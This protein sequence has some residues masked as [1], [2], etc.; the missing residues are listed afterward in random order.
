MFGRRN[1]A[2][3]AAACLAGSGDFLCRELAGWN[4]WALPKLMNPQEFAAGETSSGV[5]I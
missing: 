5:P 1:W 2:A 3:A 4:R